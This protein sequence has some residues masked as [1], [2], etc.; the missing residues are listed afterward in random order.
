MHNEETDVCSV[1]ACV[2]N[3]GLSTKA[4]KE[5]YLKGC[6]TLSLLLY[7]PLAQNISYRRF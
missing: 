7:S 1:H 5:E 6:G 2:L 4:L 3:I